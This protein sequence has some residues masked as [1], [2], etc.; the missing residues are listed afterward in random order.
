MF[1]L[2]F[3][4]IS[5][6]VKKFGQRKINLFNGFVRSYAT[7]RWEVV[8]SKNKNFKCVNVYTKSEVITFKKTIK[9]LNATQ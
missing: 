6:I 2:V 9:E 7:T 1:D 5:E 3:K 8:V 4:I